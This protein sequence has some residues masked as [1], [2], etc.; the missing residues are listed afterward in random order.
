MNPKERREKLEKLA[1]LNDIHVEVMYYRFHDKSV[2]QIAEILNLDDSTVWSRF[3]TIF[4]KLGI[5]GSNSKKE[6]ELVKEYSPIFL[7]FVKSEKDLKNWG[8]IR[9]KLQDEADQLSAQRRKISSQRLVG[10]LIAISLLILC[11]FAVSRITAAPASTPA[12]STITVSSTVST[13]KPTPQP[14]LI[15]GPNGN[16][17]VRIDQTDDTNIILLNN[18]ILNATMNKEVLDWVDISTLLQQ[19]A[20]N[21]LTAINL[22]SLNSDGAPLGSA[23]WDFSL[24]HNDIVLWRKEGTS[25]GCLMCYVQ[26]V[27]ISPDDKV[28]EV[29]LRPTGKENLPG[30]WSAKIKAGDVGA[31]T[32]NGVAVAASF[33]GQDEGWSDISPFLVKGQDNMITISVWNED[34]DYDWYASIQHNES[35]VWELSK[36]GSGQTGEVFFTAIIVDGAGNVVP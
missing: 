31:I 30:V 3:T 33:N 21:Y 18:H 35:T 14:T 25:E 13:V 10:A 6:A 17:A 26:T 11:V 9:A 2:A 20:P 1:E 23:V 32:V 27:K 22:N 16:W 29:D 12:I 7:E 24:Q 15:P 36:Y 4:K 34:R 28:E 19:G 5:G 8:P